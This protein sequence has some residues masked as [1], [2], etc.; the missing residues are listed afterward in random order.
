MTNKID[1][2]IERESTFMVI[3]LCMWEANKQNGRSNPHAVGVV[4][5]ETGQLRYIKSGSKIKFVSGE[6]TVGMNQE[7]YNKVSDEPE[8]DL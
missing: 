1:E 3:D 6:M 5:I 2:K 8:D 4:D 7:E